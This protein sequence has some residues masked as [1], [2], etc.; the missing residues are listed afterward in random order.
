MRL[1][2]HT[3]SPDQKADDTLVSIGQSPK[4]KRQT[5]YFDGD[6]EYWSPNH[7]MLDTAY[8]VLDCEIAE[9][10]TTVP[11]IEYVV[12]GKELS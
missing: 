12:R 5:D 11:E 10:A 6:F 9:D 8:V 2:L 1:T 3:G 7:R 4:F